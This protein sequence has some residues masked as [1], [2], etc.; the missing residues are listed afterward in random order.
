MRLPMVSDPNYNRDMCN[1]WPRVQIWEPKLPTKASLDPIRRH[2]LPCVDLVTCAFVAM[3]QNICPF[4][5]AT[6]EPKQAIQV[7]APG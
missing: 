1:C 5:T 6:H 7:D 3:G 2:M 4:W